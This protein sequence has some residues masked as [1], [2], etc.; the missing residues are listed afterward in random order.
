MATN[1]Y[2]PKEDARLLARGFRWCNKDCRY[3]S[4]KSLSD[5]E[6]VFLTNEL[7]GN[8]GKDGIL[9]EVTRKVGLV[10]SK[11]ET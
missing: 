9:V 5:A 2:L 11:E 1:V 6:V 7:A 3:E 4:A 8:P 10:S